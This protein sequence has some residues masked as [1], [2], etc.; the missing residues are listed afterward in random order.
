M[1]T[2]VKGDAT[3]PLQITP[4]SNCII[5]HCCNNIG[6]W[7]AGFVLE[8]SKKWSLPE[9]EY[10]KNFRKLSLGDVQVVKVSK[11]I[12]VANLIGQNGIRSKINPKPIDYNAIYKGLLR[13]NYLIMNNKNKDKITVHMPKIG[14][15]LAG[16]KWSL[17]EKIINKAINPSIPVFVYEKI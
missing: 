7:G 15:G 12:C 4:N 16:G 14:C 6:A 10:K 1:I 2:Y 13:I 11:Q 8:L 9:K 5:V 17:I 3:E